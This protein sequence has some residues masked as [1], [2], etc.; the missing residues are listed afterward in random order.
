MSIQAPSVCPAGCLL[1]TDVAARGLDIRDV[2]WTLQLDAP[3]VSSLPASLNGYNLPD[4]PS[5]ASCSAFASN[6]GRN[7]LHG[8]VNLSLTASACAMKDFGLQPWKQSCTMCPC[9]ADQ[10]HTE[11]SVLQNPDAFVHRVGRS[12]RMG[13]AG[14]ALIFLTPSEGT[15]PKFM[16]LRKV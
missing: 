9:A 14:S 4:K 15:Y 7:A 6:T 1:C 13:R 2:Q 11:L 3:Q 16:Q 12:A 8:Q 5:P 10:A